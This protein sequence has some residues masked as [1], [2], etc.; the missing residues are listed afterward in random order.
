MC[1]MCTLLHFVLGAQVFR[2]SIDHICNGLRSPFE[3]AIGGAWIRREY[4]YY[5][6]VSH[7]MHAIGTLSESD[8]V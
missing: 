4:T 8:G 1:Q 2:H 7:Q 6:K 5:L 3:S